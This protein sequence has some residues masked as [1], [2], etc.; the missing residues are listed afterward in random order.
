MYILFLVFNLLISLYSLALE[1][2]NK[3][4]AW[5]GQ[6]TIHA[7]AHASMLPQCEEAQAMLMLIR[8]AHALQVLMLASYFLAKLADSYVAESQ[9]KDLGLC[10]KCGGLNEGVVDKCPLDNCPRKA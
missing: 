9:R 6:L 1:H 7:S 2:F 4:L 10:T 3:G 5:T 8:V